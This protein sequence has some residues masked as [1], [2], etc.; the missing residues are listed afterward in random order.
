MTKETTAFNEE[1]KPYIE[2]FKEWLEE[3]D[4]TFFWKTIDWKIESNEIKIIFEFDDEGEEVVNKSIHKWS[5]TWDGKKF[6]KVDKHEKNIE[7]KI[8]IYRWFSEDEEIENTD[9]GTQ[10]RIN[11]LEKR[12][13]DYRVGKILINHRYWKKK[14]KQ[15]LVLGIISII[16]ATT[17]YL[18]WP[19]SND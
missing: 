10:K 4:H 5:L 8:L 13:T 9:S 18:M 11:E 19:K 17:I 12:L 1:N 6:N 16:L 14:K 15:F 7:L 3:N 2:I